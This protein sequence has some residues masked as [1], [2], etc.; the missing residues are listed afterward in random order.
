LIQLS[1]SRRVD[2]ILPSCWI[3]PAA[4]FTQ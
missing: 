3:L 1:S 2:P 4:S